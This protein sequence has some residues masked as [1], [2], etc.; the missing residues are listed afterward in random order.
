MGDRRIYDAARRADAGEVLLL[1][2]QGADPLWSNAQY[3]NCTALHEAARKGYLGVLRVLIESGIDVAPQPD[4]R[5]Q[6]R[7]RRRLLHRRR[8]GL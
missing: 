7:H 1:L 5:V 4:P 3:Y 6:L 8:Q 2:A